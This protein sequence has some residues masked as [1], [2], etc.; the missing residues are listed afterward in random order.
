M[1]LLRRDHLARQHHLHGNAF[2]HQSRQTLRPAVSGND[3]QLHLRLPQLR[4]FAREAHGARHRNL[5]SAAQ[6]ESVEAGNHRLAQI[7]NQVEHVLPAMRIFLAR[8]RIVL[9]QFA[10]VGPGNKRLLSQSR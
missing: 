8:H 4:V 9:G 2:A 5:A 6:R 10:D 1:R 7:F 3:S